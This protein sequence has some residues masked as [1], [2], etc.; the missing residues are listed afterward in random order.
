MHPTPGAPPKRGSWGTS[1]NILIC[2]LYIYIYI[3][4]YIRERERERQRER[5]RK[6]ERERGASRVY[7]TPYFSF[8][9][10]E[11]INNSKN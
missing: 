1:I 8:M 6:R 2:G 7:L 10:R 4:I 3:Y 5:E 9:I 11:N